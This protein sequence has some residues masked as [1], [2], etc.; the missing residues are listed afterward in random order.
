M[1]KVL[2]CIVCLNMA[3]LCFGQPVKIK[4][5][6]EREA[7]VVF[8]NERYDLKKGETRWITLEGEDMYGKMFFVFRGRGFL[9]SRFA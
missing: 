8:G 7:F 1:K 2:F 9:G 5:V 4:L 6:A 3:L